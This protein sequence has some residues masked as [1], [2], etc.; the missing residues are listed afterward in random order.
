MQTPL[1]IDSLIPDIVAVVRSAANTVLTATPGA[2]KTTRLPP[3]LL[4]TV[5]GR[6]VVLEPRR[7][8]AVS[9]CH[10]VCE[11][12]GWRV[13]S[14][15]GYQVRFES[16]ITSQTR[17]VFM[18]EALLLR[19]M[20]ENPELKGVDLI[21][22]DEFHERTLNQDLILGLVCELQELG[23]EI[24]LLLMSATLD[25]S[26][27]QTF[28]PNCA[29]LEVPG[30]SHPLEVRYLNQNL[31]L[32]CDSIFY[33]R[34]T[35]AVIN[36]HRS[37]EGD[38]L[39]FLPG[40]GEINRTRERLEGE[41]SRDLVVLH[42]SLPLSEQQK[43][44]Q[45]PRQ[46]RVIL[47]T[48]V[49]EASVTVQGVDFVIDSGL[50][51]VMETNPR[52]GFSQL[53]I[54][55]ISQFNAR[56]RAGRAAR[57]KA[58]VCLRLWSAFEEA[59]QP[60]E[61]V[62]EC[63]REDLSQSLLLLA[64]FGV[65][66]FSKFSWLEAPPAAL[67]HLAQRFLT[68]LGALDSS[69][70]LTELGHSLLKFPL[71]PRW[72][73][74]LALGERRG[75]GGLSAR[76]AALLSE[77]DIL[78]L[79]QGQG[80]GQAHPHAMTSGPDGSECDL[81][82][83]LEWLENLERGR[84]SAHI[85]QGAARA[86]LDVARQLERLVAKGETSARSGEIQR[87]LIHSQRDRICRRR[88]NSDRALMVGGRG[89][90]LGP[91]SQVRKSE[92]LVALQGV[93]LPGQADTGITLASG[94]SKEFLL[95]ELRDEVI[96]REDIYFDGDKD[97]LFERRQRVLDD[98]P[99]EEPVLTPVPP[100][101]AM[102]NLVDVVVERWARIVET[103]PALQRW[104]ERWNFLCLHEPRHRE[105]LGDAEIRQVA[106]MSAYGKSR[107][108][109]VLAQD[110]V[111][112][113]ESVLLPEARKVLREEVPPHFTAP[114]GIPHAIHYDE[115]HSAYVEVRLQEMFG[116][117][118]TPKILFGR[119]PLTFRL[120][121]PNFRPVQVTS[122]LQ[123]FWER[124]YQEVRKELRA[125]YPKHAWPEDPLTATPQAKGRR[126]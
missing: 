73:A 38:I 47:A 92:F 23:R 95:A 31:R 21:V 32:Q 8:A 71:P 118:Q 97:Q 85:R 106:E 54:A 110:L 56:Q 2:G 25:L 84:R 14:E 77:R 113:M 70:R 48:N 19:Q 98:L 37:T 51:K 24:K 1:P 50:A 96:T 9:A 75:L 74:L 125:R 109:D 78:D 87:L 55:R 69:H 6:V 53:Q 68:A 103:H 86:V 76:L 63:R 11:E 83:R 49:A 10:R 22:I 94:F 64:H 15:A 119:F 101:R 107:L 99:I 102:G 44:L 18:T 81:A 105:Y 126:R 35:D 89:I 29:V 60:I 82:L 36:A 116:L 124:G 121:G 17:L 7:M 62:P 72:G 33:E 91:Q 115:G 16:R 120:L 59:S 58:G 39:V 66:D 43:V 123:G 88:G 100:E 46:S 93:D 40:V 28:L 114:S 67:I 12:Q 52:T 30:Q 80:Q 26:R 57:E 27:L 45:P 13:G 112:Y 111:A 79:G 122:D 4:R 42:G 104:M 108:S 41:L 20:V 5:A 65:S 90:R 3:H 61:P 117:S 34:I